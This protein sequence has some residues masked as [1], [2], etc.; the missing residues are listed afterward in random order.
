MARRYVNPNLASDADTLVRAIGV[1]RRRS[2]KPSSLQLDVF[3][4]VL[5]SAAD[6]IRAEDRRERDNGLTPP[7]TGVTHP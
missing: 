4:R 2:T 6:R 7:Q 1:L 5:Q 3:C